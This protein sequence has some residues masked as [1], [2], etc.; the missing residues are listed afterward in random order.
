LKSG[1]NILNYLAESSSG[2][3]IRTG[4]SRWQGLAATQ[5]GIKKAHAEHE[6]KDGPG[7]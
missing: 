1:A 2:L 4:I 3:K 7:E 6:L 5:K